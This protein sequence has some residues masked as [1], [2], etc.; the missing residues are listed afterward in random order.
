MT[1]PIRC[2]QKL[3][4]ELSST[5]HVV[6]LGRDAVVNPTRKGIDRERRMI[7]GLALEMPVKCVRC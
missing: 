7:L 1:S 6:V 3:L 5:N 2:Y 4:S